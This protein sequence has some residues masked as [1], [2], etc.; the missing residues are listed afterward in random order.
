MTKTNLESVDK[1]RERRI[2]AEDYKKGLLIKKFY[3]R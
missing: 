1:S 2:G 3:K